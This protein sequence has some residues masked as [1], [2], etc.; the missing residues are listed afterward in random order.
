[1]PLKNILTEDTLN[2]LYRYALSLAKD[3]A[4]SY[5]LL[6]GAIEKLLQ[7]EESRLGVIDSPIAYL[8]QTIRYAFFDQLRKG[9]FELVL[10][11]ESIEEHNIKYA[12]SEPTLE[13]IHIQQRE[14]ER[15]LKRMSAEES[16]LLYLWVVEEFTFDEIAAFKGVAK[17]TLLSRMHRL[18]KRMQRNLASDGELSKRLKR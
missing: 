10:N 8:K 5:D 11:A 15:L 9:R 13:D 1:M 18:K 14:V 7:K 12:L 2:Q 17:G 6:Q 3:E 4:Q 16:E